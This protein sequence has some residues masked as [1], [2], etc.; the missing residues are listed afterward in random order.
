M[1]SAAYAANG[2]VTASYPTSCRTKVMVSEHAA[3][4]PPSSV[5]NSRLLNRSNG[6]RIGTSRDPGQRIKLAGI[7]QFCAKFQVQSVRGAWGR[8]RESSAWTPTVR[9]QGQ[10]LSVLATRKPRVSNRT[11]TLRLTRTA[12]RTN[13]LS[14]RHEP[15]RA[16]R[17]LGS[18]PRSHADP[19]VGAPW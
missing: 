19:S 6:I 14:L 1:S 17:K 18:P 11:L 7:S 8:E 13:S 4:A 12:A 5:M 9:K 2:T 10:G 15:P 3:T 16:T